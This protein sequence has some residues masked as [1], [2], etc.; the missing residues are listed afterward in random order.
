LKKAKLSLDS[1]VTTGGPAR[2]TKKVSSSVGCWH[3][4]DHDIDS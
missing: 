3:L 2:Q 1:K 4:D